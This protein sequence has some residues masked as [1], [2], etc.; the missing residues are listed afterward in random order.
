MPSQKTYFKIGVF[1]LTGVSILLAVVVFVGG[2]ELLRT[3]IPAETYF[4]ESVQGLD[5]GAPV[6]YRGVTIG[7]VG[8][9]GFIT[10]KYNVKDKNSR[11]ARYVLVEM[12]LQEDIAKDFMSVTDMQE[13]L[14]RI[15]DM[16]LRIRLTTQGLTGVA[17]LEINFFDPETNP[18]LPIEWTPEDLYFPSAPSTMSRLESALEAVGGVM[19]DLERVNFEKF[20][21][22]LD[23]FLN[24]LDTAL[25]EANVQD[26]GELLVQNLAEVRTMLKR[27]NTILEEP[28]ATRLIPDA[29]DAAASAKRML[30]QSEDKVVKAVEAIKV[31]AEKFEHTADSLDKLLADPAIR[32]SA[33]ALP[34]TLENVEKAS[35]NI[36]RSAA[37]LDRLLRGVNNIIQEQEGNIGAIV[38]DIK[39]LVE[40][41]N[42]LISDVERH[43]ARLFFSAP[44][45]QLDTEQLPEVDVR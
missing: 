4:N 38:E 15:V 28:K 25:N 21:D 41:F 36:R 22:T 17:F 24:S 16:G 43:P 20:A 33:S 34:G 30:E 35:E 12:Q 8:R 39:T 42:N 1:V 45:R 37:E 32:Q 26:I 29:A 9:I 40:G 31:A 11:A 23:K 18:P 14:R 3:T 10:N 6:K 5:V 7:R 19:R 44:P 13:R 2:S 27:V